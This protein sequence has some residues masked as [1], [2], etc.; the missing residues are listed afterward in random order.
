[1]SSNVK[2]SKSELFLNYLNT[3]K[4]EVKTKSLEGYYHVNVVADA[5]NEG[6][7]AG[8]ESG[9]KEFLNNL[10]DKEIDL[11]TDKSNQIYILSKSVISFINKKGFSASYLFLNLKYNRPSVIIA[12]PEKHLINDEFVEQAYLK[13]HENK[14]I[15]EKLFDEVL[16]ISFVSSKNLNNQ[17]LLEDGFGY[18]ESY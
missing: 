18:K 16:D 4:E 8:K 13:I 1:M 10:I 15:Y 17:L 2:T 5:Y 6:F 12:I 9:E 7:K 14:L 3:R 11:F